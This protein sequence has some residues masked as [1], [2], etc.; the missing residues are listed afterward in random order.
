M[1]VAKE[2]SLIGM[3]FAPGSLSQ[4]SVKWHSVWILKFLHP[5][6]RAWTSPTKLS[7]IQSLVENNPFDG[8]YWKFT[9]SR[10][11]L[12]DIVHRLVSDRYSAGKEYGDYLDVLLSE[13]RN[14]NPKEIED[15]LMVSLLAGRES[16]LGTFVW[17]TYEL[18]RDPKWISLLRKE[19]ETIGMESDVIPFK[20]AEKYHVHRAVLFETLRLWPGLPKNA[21]MA[22][23][24][25]VL[26]AIDASNLPA[27]KISRR[28]FV[29]WSDYS[30]MRNT[31]VW[32]PDAEEFNPKRH[33]DAH[34]RFVTP[35]APKFHGFGFGPRS[36]YGP[37]RV[38]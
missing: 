23:D 14:H 32:G 3:T 15:M 17:A 31:D 8:T 25:D 12:R 21:R 33:L 7:L 9:A 6:C 30:T 26:P 34:G 11:Y 10:K 18:C 37:I 2:Q 24:D 36:W 35:K 4:S 20:E 28:D 38:I 16:T 19:I 5:M 1:P 22:M 27:V 13:E 29:L